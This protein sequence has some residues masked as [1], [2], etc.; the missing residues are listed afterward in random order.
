MDERIATIKKHFDLVIEYS[1]EERGIGIFR[2]FFI[3]YTKGLRGTKP[4]RDKAF[5]TNKKDQFLEIIEELRSFDTI[6]SPP[7]MLNYSIITGNIASPD[8]ALRSLINI[9]LAKSVWN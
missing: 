7:N 6:F 8:L 3:W 5:R 2:K 1:G 9:S 4:L